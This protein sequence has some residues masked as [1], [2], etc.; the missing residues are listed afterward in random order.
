[1]ASYGVYLAA[2]GF[3]YHGPKGCLA[4]DPRV[5][6]QDFR[7]AFA[8]AEGWGTFSQKINGS[9]KTAALEIK[10]GKL[11]LKTFALAAEAAPASVHA[12]VNGGDVPVSSSFKDGRV[13]IAFVPDLLLA[14]GHQ[15]HIAL[16]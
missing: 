5:S 11:R 8:S 16:T 3:D 1:M 13:S 12:Q 10:W 7:A 9:E 4:F 2:C 14:K 6:P 15:L